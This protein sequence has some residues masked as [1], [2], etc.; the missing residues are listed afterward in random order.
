MRETHAAPHEEIRQAR[1]RQ[2][3]VEHRLPRLDLVHESQE[4][5]RDLQRDGGERAAAPVDEGEP[6]RRHAV[7]GQRLEGAGGAERGGIRDGEHGDAD[8]DVEDGRQDLDPGEA[9]GDDEGAVRGVGAGRVEQPV[10][11][12]GHDEA[13]DEGV[14]D[15][16]EKHAPEDLPRRFGQGGAGRA[17]FGGGEAGEFRA[18]EGEGGCHEDGAE[19]VEAVAEGAGGDPIARA[20]VAAG[21]GRDAPAV[22]D[23][24]EDDEA[25]AGEDFDEAEGELDCVE[26]QC[27]GVGVVEGGVGGYRGRRGR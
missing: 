27:F 9:D 18:A 8:D 5:A 11:I 23:D 12:R 13:E 17:G 15:V 10:V 25:Q 22:D 20:D 1:Q 16:E 2:Q 6:A 3:P 24:A 19:A 21:V 14:D 7:R 26:G 4:R